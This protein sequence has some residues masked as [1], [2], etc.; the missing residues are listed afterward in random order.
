MSHEQFLLGNYYP[1]L[2]SYPKLIPRGMLLS[3][4][5]ILMK[6]TSE[7]RNQFKNHRK[8]GRLFN[9]KQINQIKNR[10]KRNYLGNEIVGNSLVEEQSRDLE[11]LRELRRNRIVRRLLKRI[12]RRREEVPKTPAEQTYNDFLDT[13]RSY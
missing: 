13:F 5:N 3:P 2:R 6:D 11:L 10:R 9:Q 4:Q 1:E 7:I 12:T 8:R